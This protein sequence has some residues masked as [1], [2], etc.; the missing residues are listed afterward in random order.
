M[1][2]FFLL[3]KH[4]TIIL[5]TSSDDLCKRGGRA[6]MYI[7]RISRGVYVWRPRW[8]YNNDNSNVIRTL[9]ART[10]G[11]RCFYEHAV[12][13]KR[14]ILLLRYPCVYYALINTPVSFCFRE[15]PPEKRTCFTPR[16]YIFSVLL[17]SFE[18][19]HVLGGGGGVVVDCCLE[20]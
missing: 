14:M 19:L 15:R 5:Y 10:I 18:T 11:A 3:I 4:N 20:K 8:K 1:N 6:P 2:N 9:S 16:N 13:E 17:Q 7:F 12:Y